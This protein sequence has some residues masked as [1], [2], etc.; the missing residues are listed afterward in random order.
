MKNYEILEI[1]LRQSAYEC[2]CEPTD[3]MKDTN[4]VV[5]SKAHPKARC[6]LSLPLECNLVS[7]GSNIVAQT[8]SQLTDLVTSYIEKYPIE[9]CFETPNMHVL[10]EGLKKHDLKICFMAEYFLPDMDKLQKLPCEY[11]VKILHNDDFKDLYTKEWS[12]ALCE[13][14]KEKD[15]LGVG[16]YDDGRLMLALPPIKDMA[17]FGQFITQGRPSHP[18]QRL[19]TA[20]W[21]CMQALHASC[22]TERIFSLVFL[23]AIAI[24]A[25]SDK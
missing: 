25:K 15:V 24:R 5:R 3:F 9:H 2:N 17:V 11:Q 12:N 1:A 20:Y 21:D 6:Y 14:R 4:V 18:R 23:L 19:V 10:N 16:A 13:K 22:T 8:S 7:Y